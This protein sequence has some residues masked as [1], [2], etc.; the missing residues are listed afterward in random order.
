VSESR[1]TRLGFL[2]ASAGLVTGAG[3]AEAAASA[4][5]RWSAP[6]PTQSPGLPA[7][8]HAW[9]EFLAVDAH[10]NPVAPRSARLLFFDVARRPAPAD[11]RRFEAALRRLE[12]LYPWRSD[13]LLFSLGWG[14]RYFEH[15]LGAPSPVPAPER[16][17]DFELPAFDEFHACLHLA[18]DDPRRLVT[19][20]RALRI[21]LRATLR[22]RETRT[23][24]V[25]NGLPRQHGRVGGLP[26]GHPIP[27]AAPLYMG[28]KSGFRKAQATEDDVTIPGGPFAGGTTMHVSYMRLRLDSWYGVLDERERVARM[29]SPETTP[30]DVE[31]LTDDAPS[32]PGRYAAAAARYGVVGHS[33]ASAR[34]RRNG[35]PRIIRR[36]F[37]TD[38][39]GVAGLHF[40]AVQRSIA[41]FVA[42]RKAMNAADASYL[43]PAISDTVNNGINEFIFVLKRGNYVVPA[44]AERSFPLLP[45]RAA[46]LA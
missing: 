11:V 38:D 4:L 20:E 39:G 3:S 17:S 8:Q 46:A 37:D 29:Y 31:R 42:T 30:A 33:Q 35:R 13:G 28:F 19:V 7:S 23:G 32:D 14:P 15:V 2:A 10:G 45:G 25:G 41:D 18:S 26:P 1:L 24:F 9:S 40:V 27:A 5:E 22:W 36:D 16:L 6:L 21:D 12:R 43:N 34:A 44:R